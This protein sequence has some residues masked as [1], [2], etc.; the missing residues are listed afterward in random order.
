MVIGNVHVCII[1]DDDYFG[2]V[3]K[4]MKLEVEKSSLCVCCCFM[5]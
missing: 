5:P 2:G 1:N 3:V 4:L